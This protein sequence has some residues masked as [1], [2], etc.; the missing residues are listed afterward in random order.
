MYP[1]P[2]PPMNLSKFTSNIWE[3]QSSCEASEVL[4][5]PFDE[6]GQITLRVFLRL[7]ERGSKLHLEE[8]TE[9]DIFMLKFNRMLFDGVTV[10]RTWIISEN[11]DNAPTDRLSSKALM[12]LWHQP[13]D[14]WDCAVL[15]FTSRSK[16]PAQS[17]AS[18]DF[19]H[20]LQASE[21]LSESFLVNNIVTVTKKM[22][23]ENELSSNVKVS[24]E[25]RKKRQKRF[26]SFRMNDGTKV[27]FYARTG[28][29][30][31]L[32]SCGLKLLIE[33]VQINL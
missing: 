12:K 18:T 11:D 3:Q 7:L 8:K 2:T 17:Q 6:E 31:S 32:L 25:E 23:P 15:K 29:D 22:P 13:E 10:E 19:Q 14:S 33:R 30:A 5:P 1:H 20:P 27:M 26:V 21:E 28:K 16:S 24:N 9:M 4:E